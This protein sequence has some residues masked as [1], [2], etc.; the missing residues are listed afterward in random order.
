MSEL[1]TDPTDPRLG[2]G[3]DTTPVP[4]NDAYLVLSDTERAKGFVRPVRRKYVHWYTLDGS[5]LPVVVTNE[6]LKNIRGCGA[7]TTMSQEIAE[8]YARNPNF[9]GSTYCVGCGMHRPV[10]EFT[11]DKDREVVGS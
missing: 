6:D 8:T 10:A 9:Y 1:T 4:Q 7:L 11:W 5:P 3:S 2:H